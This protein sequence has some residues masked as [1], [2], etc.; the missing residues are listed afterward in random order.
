MAY[1]MFPKLTRDQP[2]GREWL[3]RATYILLNVGLVMRV[4]SEPVMTLQSQPALGWALAASAVLQWLAGMGF[5]INTWGR[6]KE[7]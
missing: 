4:V 5:V 2:G 6:V 7:K 3:G 1:W